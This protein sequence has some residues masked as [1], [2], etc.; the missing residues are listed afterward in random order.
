MGKCNHNHVMKFNITH[1][2]LCRDHESPSDTA[3]RRAPH[4]RSLLSNAKTQSNPEKNTK[5]KLR[6]SPQNTCPPH[7]K[8]VENKERTRSHKRPKEIRE[9]ELNELW[10]TLD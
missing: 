7:I 6:G 4:I 1:D 2:G 9:I 8:V 10:Y 5:F 3:T